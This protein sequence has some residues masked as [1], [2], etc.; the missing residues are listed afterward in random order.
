METKNYKNINYDKWSDNKNK[1]VSILSL[2]IYQLEGRKIEPIDTTKLNEGKIYIIIDTHAKRTKIWIWSGAKSNMMD[3]YFAGVSATKI[4]AK[5]KL[6]GASIEVVESGSEPEQFPKLA[7]LEGIIERDEEF[8]EIL[9]TEEESE[10][11]A[12]IKPLKTKEPKPE[13]TEPIGAEV[14]EEEI[15]SK[16]KSFLKDLSNDMGEIQKKISTF[17]EGI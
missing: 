14:N 3:R 10:L 4:K 2:K 13:F 11:E 6:Y 1:M 5:K 17:L 7:K 12:E 16:L 9:L 15:I 8:E